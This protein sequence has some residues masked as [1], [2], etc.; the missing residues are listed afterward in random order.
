MVR[1]GRS[2]LRGAACALLGCGGEPN[3]SAAPGAT[4]EAN[5]TSAS[6]SGGVADSA[7]DNVTTGDASATATTS[8]TASGSGPQ[9]STGAD[10]GDRGEGTTGPDAGMLPPYCHEACR[11]TCIAAQVCRRG[12]CEIGCDDQNDCVAGN[13]CRDFGRGAQCAQSCRAASDCALAGAAWGEDHWA[14]D[15]GACNYLGC[16]GDDECGPGQVCR[17]HPGIIELVLGYNAP[18]CVPACTTPDDCDLGV[19]PTTADNFACNDGGCQW[20][21]CQGDAECPGGQSCG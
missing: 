4:S 5:A 12:R 18:T 20:L 9:A 16:A 3:D 17:E 10:A 1:P 7:G 15:G 21:G 19:E 13:V 2:S 8:E 11:D 14:C 6:G